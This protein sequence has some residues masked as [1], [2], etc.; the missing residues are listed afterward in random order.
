VKLKV[1]WIGKT[2]DKAI[3]SLSQEYLKRLKRYLPAEGHELRDQAALADWLAK[4]RTRPTLVIF[5]SRGRQ[6]SSEELAS[7]LAEHQQRG[8][9]TL[10]F[11]IGPSDGWQQEMHSRSAASISLGKMTFSHELARV[12]VME[13]LYRACTIL[14]GHPYHLGH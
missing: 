14:A 12:M 1:A 6:M 2:K 7:F 3:Q 10:V 13:Q 9:Q 8:T 4:E 11:A 5:D